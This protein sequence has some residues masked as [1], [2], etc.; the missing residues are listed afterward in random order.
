LY[1]IFYFEIILFIH[2]ITM[3]CN[4][5]SWYPNFDVEVSMES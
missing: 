5:V 3:M 1:P 2:N 4:T